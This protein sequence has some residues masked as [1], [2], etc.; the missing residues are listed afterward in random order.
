[1]EGFSRFLQGAGH[2]Y[3]VNRT[4]LD[5]YLDGEFDFTAEMVPPSPPSGEPDPYDRTN[6]QTIFTVLQEQLGLKLESTRGP[7]EVLVIDSV[8]RP[9]PD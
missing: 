8:E 1:M 7:V 5:G 9:T 2:R 6:L 4:G 3:V